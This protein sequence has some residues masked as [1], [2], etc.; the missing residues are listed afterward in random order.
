M[1]GPKH[2]VE[3]NER[4]SPRAVRQGVLRGEQRDGLRGACCKKAHVRRCDVRVGERI[5]DDR[6]HRPK[7][8]R[9]VAE[10]AQDEDV[11]PVGGASLRPAHGVA[12]QAA[13]ENRKRIGAGGAGT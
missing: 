5:E 2:D 6:L 3:R 12:E 7:E 1:P 9:E 10:G 13:E 4:P 11:P 8:R